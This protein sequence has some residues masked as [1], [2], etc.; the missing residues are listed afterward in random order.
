LVRQ[1]VEIEC[2]LRAPVLTVGNA[3]TARDFSDVR[4]IVR[5]YVLLLERGRPGEVYQLCSGRA[6][7]VR[8]IIE[9]LVA[10]ASVPIEV[11]V[12]ATKA[13]A[14]ESMI[15]WGDAAKARSEVGWKPRHDLETTLG[16]LKTY[17][18]KQIGEQGAGRAVPLARARPEPPNQGS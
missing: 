6:V 14:G 15:S 4:D 13:H 18:R 12:E 17:W 11:R 1:A 2:G 3:D 7:S 5:G 9:R 16:D 10:S 8:A